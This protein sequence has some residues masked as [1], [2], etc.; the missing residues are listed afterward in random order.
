[1]EF[2]IATGF[3]RDQRNEEFTKV[4]LS[5]AAIREI[6]SNFFNRQDYA[7][8]KRWVEARVRANEAFIVP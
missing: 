6:V 4:D 5:E 2:K 8:N 7:T 1:M 3:D